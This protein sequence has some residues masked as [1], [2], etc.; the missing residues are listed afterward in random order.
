MIQGVVKM[1]K[2][3]FVV[4][5]FIFLFSFASSVTLG[6]GIVLN[7]TVSNSSVNFSFSVNVSNFTIEQNYILLNSINFT[8]STGSYTCDDLNHS[9]ANLMI[10][11]SEFNC[12]IVTAP[13]V[14]EEVVTPSTS[15]GVSAYLKEKSSDDSILI[16][17]I[18][19][20]SKEKLINISD[21]KET[22]ITSLKIRA[23]EYINGNI[24]IS[25]LDS[26]PDYC[27][28]PEINNYEIYKILN[29]N[30]SFENEKIDNL[31]IDIIINKSWI[32][33]KNFS[34]II[35]LKCFPESKILNISLLDKNESKYKIQSDGFSVWVIGGVKKIEK[36]II[37]EDIV[38][39]EEV[40]RGFWVTVGQV[41]G[42]R[43]GKININE[44][45]VLFFIVLIL[46]VLIVLLRIRREK[47]RTLKKRKKRIRKYH[48]SRK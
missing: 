22:G 2:G 42:E 27:I 36:D 40:E 6:H 15:G 34:E 16:R 37:D 30:H 3:I 38:E 35:A 47:E 13:P 23:K 21:S 19:V 11:S 1:Y 7:T 9:T 8:N 24:E 12:I 20:A 31:E 28:M 25:K 39:V 43:I 14:V 18:I 33:E 26:K 10:D 44:L 4:L 41:I 45:V 5:G 32:K 46:V 17:I 29:L 48:K